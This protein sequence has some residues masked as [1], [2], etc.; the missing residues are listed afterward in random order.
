GVGPNGGLLLLDFG[1][2]LANTEADSNENHRA[3]ALVTKQGDAERTDFASLKAGELKTLSGPFEWVAIKSKYFVA[4]VLAIDSGGP[5]I[6]GATGIPPVTAGKRPASADVQ[7]SLPVTAAGTFAYSVYA[8]PMEY[9][10]LRHIG[11][12][13]DDVNPYGWPGFRTL[14]RF[15]TV[16]IRWL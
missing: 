14:I 12:D 1:P 3:L 9:D 16:P 5:A 4:A 15:F 10:R 2:G 13:F 7:L 6:G 11:H 8:G